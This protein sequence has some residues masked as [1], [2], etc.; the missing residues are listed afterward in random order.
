MN[1]PNYPDPKQGDAIAQAHA[2][3]R[4][5]ADDFAAVFGL[6]GKR[7]ERQNRVLEHLAQTCRDG[8]NAFDFSGPTDG[9]T[10]L[11]AGIHRDGAQSILRIIERQCAISERQKKPAP[12]G[13]K[14]KR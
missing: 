8:S 14:V 10:R 2:R 6:V 11:A 7:S 9:I 3:A 13:P 5:L 12:I 4:Q 1:A